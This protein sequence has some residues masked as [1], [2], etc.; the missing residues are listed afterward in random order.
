LNVP[1]KT[2]SHATVHVAEDDAS[3]ACAWCCS[4][5]CALA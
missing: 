1:N 3:G 5:G 2:P 4:D